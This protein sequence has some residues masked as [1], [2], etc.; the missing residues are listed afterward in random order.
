MID[1]VPCGNV[2]TSIGLDNYVANFATITDVREDGAHAIKKMDFIV[3]P[4]ENIAIYKHM[5]P[6]RYPELMGCFHC[7]AKS[8]PM[9]MLQTRASS[10][11]I[12]SGCGTH[13]LESISE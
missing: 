12:I 8:N 2:A 1:E 3:S 11:I 7:L 13:Q 10:E 4:G 5:S 9:F 6:G